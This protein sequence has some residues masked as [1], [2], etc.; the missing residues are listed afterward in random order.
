[1]RLQYSEQK[2]PVNLSPIFAMHGSVTP[3]GETHISSLSEE[4]EDNVNEE[5]EDNV[6][7]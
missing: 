6:K 4:S 3:S 2:P 1:M 7:N 5:A